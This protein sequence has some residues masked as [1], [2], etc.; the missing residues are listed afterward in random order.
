MVMAVLLVCH[1]SVHLC[2]LCLCPPLS[3]SLCLVCHLSVHL[4]HLCLCPPLSVSLCLVCH[5][6]LYTSFCFLS[7]DV[8]CTCFYVAFLVFS[9]LILLLSL[10]FSHFYSILGC[11]L[12]KQEVALRQSHATF[13]VLCYPCQNRSLLPHNVISPTTFWSSD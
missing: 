5:L 9:F 6:L 3:V 8:F 13:S 4:C 2:H 10:L 1:L 11:V 7:H 12:P